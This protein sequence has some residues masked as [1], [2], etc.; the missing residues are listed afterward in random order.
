[1]FEDTVRFTRSLS[2]YEMEGKLK[3]IVRLDTAL[4]QVFE[5]PGE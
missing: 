1:M 4:Y 5:E 3:D 2:G